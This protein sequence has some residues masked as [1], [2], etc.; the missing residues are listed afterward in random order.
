MPN[1]LEMSDRE[2]FTQF[3]RRTGMFLGRTTLTGAM[4]FLVGYDQGAAD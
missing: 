4:A 1:L 2:Y 3:A